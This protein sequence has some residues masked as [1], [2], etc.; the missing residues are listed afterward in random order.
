MT[1]R[2][3]WFNDW[4]LKKKVGSINDILDF[5][6]HTGNGD[7]HNSLLMNRGGQLYTVSI[8]AMEIGKTKGQMVYLDLRND[9]IFDTGISFTS[10]KAAL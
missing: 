6:R 8:T 1:L 4:L 2:E 9:C 10:R 3:S 5:H 7:L